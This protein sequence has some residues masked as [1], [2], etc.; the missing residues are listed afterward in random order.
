MER[1]EPVLPL[2]KSL[3]PFGFFAVLRA[4]GVIFGGIGGALFSL[5]GFGG[6]KKREG[7]VGHNGDK[8]ACKD[9]EQEE[10]KAY[11]PCGEAPPFGDSLTHSKKKPSLR[12]VKSAPGV[13]H[14]ALLYG[15]F[16]L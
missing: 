7:A 13:T 14:R 16:L 10:N 12:P 11:G 6:H 4:G 9:K 1:T 5:Y 2:K 3:F 8:A 15:S